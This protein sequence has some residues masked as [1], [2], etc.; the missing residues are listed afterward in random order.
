MDG[1]ALEWVGAVSIVGGGGEGEIGVDVV[2][3]GG[4]VH[5][6]FPASDATRI[7]GFFF[8]S[9]V[10]DFALFLFSSPPSSS[11]SF[12]F[13]SLFDFFFLR[14]PFSLWSASS[15]GP[16]CS[17]P[18]P[19][20]S[21]SISPSVSSFPLLLPNSEARGEKIEERLIRLPLLLPLPFVPALA[22]LSRWPHPDVERVPF[23]SSLSSGWDV[24]GSE[25]QGGEGAVGLSRMGV[26]VPIVM[27]AVELLRRRRDIESFAPSLFPKDEA[28]EEALGVEVVVEKRKE[29][30]R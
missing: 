9:E 5:H 10:V 12:P 2:V 20:P 22:T 3:V 24:P 30:R 15:F 16:S 18:P 1:A 27:V 13:F 4:D 21:R 28:V 17:P 8:F 7:E 14:L 19:P 29:G 25:A 23:A 26:A 6:G 11:S